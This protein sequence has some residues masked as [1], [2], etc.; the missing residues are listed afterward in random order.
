MEGD[1]DQAAMH[2]TMCVGARGRRVQLAPVACSAP[3]GC[4][5]VGRSG[6][7]STATPCRLASRLP[8]TCDIDGPVGRADCRAVGR[9]GGRVGRADERSCSHALVP[10]LAAALVQTP[11][12]DLRPQTQPRLHGRTAAESEL[13]SVCRQVSN[14][15][16]RASKQDL[17]EVTA[18]MATACKTL[19]EALEA[20]AP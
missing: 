9:P 20:R 10:D 14:V 18:A 1:W 2:R 4:R 8:S 15:L 17:P 6:R 13:Q 5:S 11:S 3:M 19:R 7:G 12:A 16:L